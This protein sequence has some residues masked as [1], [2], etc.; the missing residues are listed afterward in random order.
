MAIPGI[1]SETPLDNS[2]TVNTKKRFI[3]YAESN[4]EICE[5]S[6]Q[7]SDMKLKRNFHKPIGEKPDMICQEMEQITISDSKR[8]KLNGIVQQNPI[9]PL[10]RI[11]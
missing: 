6:N 9:S 5:N 11:Q 10:R 2:E 7:K 4:V 3:P 8:D 1:S